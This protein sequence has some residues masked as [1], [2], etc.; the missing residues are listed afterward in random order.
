M[1]PHI[2][3]VT[4]SKNGTEPS[5]KIK[6]RGISLD[7]CRHWNYREVLSIV[8]TRPLHVMSGSKILPLMKLYLLP[9]RYEENVCNI[10]SYP[11][12]IKPDQ[13]DVLIRYQTLP[14]KLLVLQIQIF[15]ACERDR[16]FLMS[17][18]CIS[19]GAKFETENW[20]A[21][22]PRTKLLWL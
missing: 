11:A 19:I 12:F 21:N 15:L 2:W 7:I 20:F 1:W 18:N 22:D 13:R 4:V 16:L 6:L 17:Q 10:S 8:S 3:R 9:D 5:V 14:F